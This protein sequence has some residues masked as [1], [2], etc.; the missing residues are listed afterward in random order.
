MQCMLCWQTA[1]SLE[2]VLLYAI[3][4]L[5]RVLSLGTPQVAEVR[6]GRWV[7]GLLQITDERVE[8]A[9]AQIGLVNVNNHL[10]PES[11]QLED[12]DFVVLS[13]EILDI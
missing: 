11:T 10:V 7:Q 12:G 9:N 3:T 4:A 6:A 5:H 8:A 13:R 1:G 2:H